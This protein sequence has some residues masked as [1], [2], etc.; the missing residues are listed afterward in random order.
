[1]KIEAEVEQAATTHLNT[2]DVDTAL[3]HF[4]DDVLAISNVKLFPSRE[5]L[6][7]DIGGYYKILKKVNY[8]SWE[9]VHIHV[10]NERAATFTAKFSYGFTSTDDQITDLKGVWTAL[11]ILDKGIWKIR[12]RHESFELI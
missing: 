8:A 9:D 2:K 1:M 11:F 12:L 3:S 4:T 6:A 10:I 5:S 7:A